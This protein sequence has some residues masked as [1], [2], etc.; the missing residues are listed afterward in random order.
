M[1]DDFQLGLLP[2]RRMNWRA[3]AASYGIEA[4]LLILLLGAGLLFPQQIE[5]R[6]RFTVTELIPMPDLQPKP[7]VEPAPPERPRLVSP[8]PIVAFPDAKLFV[9]KDVQPK[10]KEV[11]VAPP[12]LE[13]KLT[14][15]VLPQTKHLPVR[16]VYTGSFGSSAPATVSAPI[17]QVQTSG[18]GDPNGLKGE[19]K[20]GAHLVATQLG[21]FDLPPG[22]GKGNGTGGAHGVAGAIASAGFGTGIAQGVDRNPVRA[23]V[24]SSFGSQEVVR[25][26]AAAQATSGPATAPVEIVAKFRPVYSEEARARKIE[27]EVLLE[28]LF[29]ANGQ[30]HVNR[31]VQGLGYGL[32]EAAIAAANKMQFRPALQNGS[33]V[34]S[35]A[36]VHVVFQLAY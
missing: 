18:F 14:P 7:A 10:P 36:I 20:P 17:Q 21:S 24:Q 35:T 27:G 12:K 33:P 31:I 25:P 9:P 11:E 8:P 22:P 28:V 5:L 1:P 3:V 29:G 2:E 4:V 23:V 13:A 19:G 6:Q 26:T 16:A 34:D 15:P 30:L 32:D